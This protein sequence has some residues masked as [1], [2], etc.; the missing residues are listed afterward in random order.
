MARVC[1]VKMNQKIKHHGRN[2]PEETT[3]TQKN[4]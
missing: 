4:Q 2:N 1:K 3:K